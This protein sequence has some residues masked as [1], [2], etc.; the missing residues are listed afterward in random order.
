M[1]KDQGKAEKYKCF[2]KG[3]WKNKEL[4]VLPSVNP[5]SYGTDVRNPGHSPFIKDKSNFEVF[6]VSKGEVFNFGK[7]KETN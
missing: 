1:L 4:L 7:V 2:L 6:V 5:L 3:K